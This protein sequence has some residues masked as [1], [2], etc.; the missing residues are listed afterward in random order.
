M[1][2]IYGYIMPLHILVKEILVCL[3]FLLV[4]EG[5]PPLIGGLQID[6]GFAVIVFQ[7]IARNLLSVPESEVAPPNLN[8]V[9]VFHIQKS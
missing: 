6:L 1:G 2:F 7:K 4:G 5:F 8:V 9:I 3:C